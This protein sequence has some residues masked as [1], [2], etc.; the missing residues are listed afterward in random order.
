MNFVNLETHLENSA[1]L[2]HC[3]NSPEMFSKKT[4]IKIG[5]K[6]FEVNKENS[7]INFLGAYFWN[8]KK[9]QYIGGV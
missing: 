6:N 9:L 7:A 1:F 5:D 4:S 2:G 8:Q 3:L